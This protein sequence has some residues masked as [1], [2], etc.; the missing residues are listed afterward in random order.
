MVIG[1]SVDAAEAGRHGASTVYTVNGDAFGAYS[2]DAWVK[3]LAA[4]IEKASP[5][6]GTAVG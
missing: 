5:A 4:V 2:T 3:A 1:G 6:V